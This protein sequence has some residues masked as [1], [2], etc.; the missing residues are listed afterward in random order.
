MPDGGGKAAAGS[1]L[2]AVA[3]ASLR[4][5]SVEQLAIR[6]RRRGRGFEYLDDGGR[7]LTD[8]ATLQRIRSLAIPPAY[9]EVRIA[10]H[11]DAHLQAVGRDDAGRLQYRYHPGWDAVRERRKSDQLADFC[12]A[13]PRIR[14][15]IARDLGARGLPRRRVLAAVVTLIDRTHIRIGCEDY[16]HSGRSRGAATLLKRNVRCRGERVALSFNGKGGREICC[17]IECAPLGRAI[18]ALARLPGRRLFQYRDRDGKLRRVTA[19]DVNEYL[20]EIAGLPVSAKNFRT[21]AASAVAAEMLSGLEPATSRRGRRK[22]IAAVVA[23]VSEM[24]G[25]TPAVARKSYVLAEVLDAFTGERLQ[26]ARKGKAARGLKRGEALV[27]RLI[28]G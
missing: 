18:T 9:R 8:A 16:V 4:Q 12:A 13:L 17:E 1:G 15:R 24:L 20:Q 10:R 2:T 5:I 28:G 6:R 25:N 11:A 22:Q 3:D 7:R 26:A 19:G 21:L 27:S 23:E 14:R